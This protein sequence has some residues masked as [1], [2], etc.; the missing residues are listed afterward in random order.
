MNVRRKVK[1]DLHILIL[2]LTL[3]VP[4]AK[5]KD[6]S[7]PQLKYDSIVKFGTEIRNAG[8]RLAQLELNDTEHR[9]LLIAKLD[10]LSCKFQQVWIEFWNEYPKDKRKFEW[11]LTNASNKANYIHYWRD[12]TE[13]AK[14]YTKIPKNIHQYTA[15]I[16][17]ASYNK[18]S[19]Q[20]DEMAKEYFCYIDSIGGK[21]NITTKAYYLYK[22]KNYLKLCQNT[23]FRPS[24]DIMLEKIKEYFLNTAKADSF[25]IKNERDGFTPYLSDYY[26]LLTE[27]FFTR[28][29]EFDLTVEDILIFITSFEDEKNEILKGW[30]QYNMKLFNSYSVPLPFEGK[31]TKGTHLNIKDFKGQVVLLDLWSIGCSSCIAAFPKVNLLLEKYK[32]KGFS[33]IAA[34]AANIKS[35]S[36][37][38]KINSSANVKWE[39]V[40]FSEDNTG[41]NFSTKYLSDYAFF[42]F[43]RYLLLNKEGKTISYSYFLDSDIEAKILAAL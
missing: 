42:A 27:Q 41:K 30:Q 39:T 24:K 17:T 21:D 34:C 7:N 16:D 20:L 12:R 10:S 26:Q 11:F 3:T 1:W 25:G 35:L 8:D 28:I 5:G 31:T 2:L 4:K 15:E 23:A 37:I 9:A 43:P 14:L 6:L 38:E 13:G 22:L 18:N 29:D 33:V 19:R 40:L 32:D 36:K